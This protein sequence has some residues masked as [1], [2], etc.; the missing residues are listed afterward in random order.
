MEHVVWPGRGGTI[1]NALAFGV[2][3]GVVWRR[4]V[5]VGLELSLGLV[6]S[7]CTFQVEMS[8]I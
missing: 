1:V 2:T 5:H 8:M 7:G 6:T 3:F 4:Y